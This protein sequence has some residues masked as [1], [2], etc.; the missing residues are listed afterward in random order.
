M[1]E[2]TSPPRQQPQRAVDVYDAAVVEAKWRRIWEERGDYRTDLSSSDRPFYNLSMF[3][4]PSAEGLHVGHMVP[5]SGADVYGRWR[6]LRGDNV[7]QPMGFDAFGIHSE[8]YALKIGEHPA[9]VMRR[10]VANFRENQLK[11]IGAMF[12]WEHQVN[13]ADPAYYRWT[14]WLFLRLFDA[15]LVEWRDGAVLWC[16]SCL[17]VLA[18]EQVEQGRCERCESVVETRWL[19]QW[20]LKITRYAQELLD[21]LD[22]LDW[23]ESTKLMQRNW[24]GR[25]EGA[26]IVF[27][28]EGCERRDVAVFTTRPD[29]LFGA[30]FVVIAADHPQLEEFAPTE[31]RGELNAWRNRLPGPE[32]D[33]DFAVGFDLRATAVHPLS[34]ARLPVWAAPYVLYDYGT[35]AIM[36]VPAHDD[37]DHAF[38]SAH[39]LPILEVISGGDGSGAHTGEG[40]MVNSGDFD[41]LASE[42]GRRRIVE[43]LENTMRG[44]ATITYRLRDWLIS[45]QR[46]WGPPIPI[47][48]CPRDG[49][50]P[51]PDD[52][53]PVLLPEVDDF[54]PT[55]TGVSPLATVE[56]WVNVTCPRCGGPARRETD[57][58]D[59]FVDSSWYYLRYPST[60]FD[61]V[62][63]DPERTR[64]WLPVDM[65]IGG[66]EHAVRHLLYSRF[67]MRALHEM[68]LV[69]EPEP[70]T[71]FRA[72]GM[73]VKDGFK[74][75][76]SRGNV[77][78][79]D[80][81]IDRYGADTFRL[82]L[83]FLGPYTA[84]GDF[85]DEGIV[86]VTR[87]LHRVWRAVQAATAGDPDDEVRERR[88]HRLIA[89]VDRD[90]AG[91]H[92]NTAIAQL[93]EFAR[94]L[95]QEAADG[96]GRR[97]DAQ[98]L[99]LCLAPFA[100]H[101]TEELWQRAG[102]EGSVHDRG[103]WP[104]HD[105]ALA[106]RLEAEVAVQV[107]GKLRGTLTVA[108]GTGEEELRRRALELPRVV[109]ILAG[110]EPRKVVAVVD[111]VVNVVV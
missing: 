19:R 5:Y 52:Q 47:I 107:N 102:H 6:R 44:E 37:R 87:F 32:A 11:K 17:T 60:D 30:T 86:G 100:P 35:G 4:Y 1:T 26:R 97:L 48:H 33:P 81:Y 24:I 29:T 92:F 57:V 96:R 56:D 90:I 39:T 54:R 95:Y 88:R 78:N 98:T 108:A 89:G 71:R 46:Y 70:F 8:N 93:M 31:R 80:D 73:I 72:H 50:V 63:F 13:T 111:R 99:L 34:G 7:F 67:V 91:L 101:I 3:P 14:Q 36:A 40:V 12:D 74:M 94:D 61:D 16:P 27:D 104:E 77:V 53:L 106:A 21:S 28:L 22:T 23:S 62:A 76:K 105:P 83:L 20:W 110:A 85:R 75:S 82:F 2:A 109:G 38:A 45:R 51:V 64:R 79:P 42:E 59:T 66:N 10:A 15:G 43:R 103:G 18:N 84:G 65:Y 41:G 58:S 55:G 69:G 49:Q 68:G 9:V 25:R